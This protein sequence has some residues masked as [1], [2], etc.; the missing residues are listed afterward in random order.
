[1]AHTLH[2]AHHLGRRFAPLS[3]PAASVEVTDEMR[4]IAL[5]RTN[6]MLGKLDELRKRREL[7]IE[8]LPLIANAYE[9]ALIELRSAE[10]RKLEAEE[11]RQHEADLAQWLSEH[12]SGDGHPH[13]HN[14]MATS[15][16]GG[17]YDSA[18]M[19]GATDT[20]Y[21][22]MMD[23]LRSHVHVTPMEAAP[24]AEVLF[25]SAR[26]VPRNT[27]VL[28]D[29]LHVTR[30]I[31]RP[32]AIGM[33]AFKPERISILCAQPADWIV[34]DILIGNRTQFASSG[35][36]PGDMFAVDAIDTFLSFETC[37]T[38][39]AIEFRV[40]YI[41]PNPE[42]AVFEAKMTGKAAWASH[43]P[44]PVPPPVVVKMDA[45]GMP[46]HLTPGVTKV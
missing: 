25:K 1:M 31:A 17:R 39:M 43:S 44:G 10:V 7:P 6:D 27:H 15:T 28:P 36:L 14:F 4:V 42:G 33:I 40:V 26:P 30:V 8:M 11:T 21:G 12:G 18:F 41:G 23:R 13:G 46:S 32:D 20:V 38:A 16:P 19:P 9:T 35:D 22:S 29:E 3:D 34:S 24:T 5:A 45:R 2:G 37:Q